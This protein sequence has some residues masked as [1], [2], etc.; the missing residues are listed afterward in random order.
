MVQAIAKL[1]VSA[2]LLAII[3]AETSAGISCHYSSFSDQPEIVTQAIERCG[4]RKRTT[5]KDKKFIA[6]GIVPH[7]FLAASLIIEYFQVLKENI[8][9][10]NIVI[11]GPDHYHQGQR[12]ISLTD[13]QW[14]TPFGYLEVNQHIAKEMRD[15]IGSRNF[16]HEA[17]FN[18][19]SIGNIVPFIKYFFP[20]AKII[21]IILK[22]G[23]SRVLLE[24]LIRALEGFV[25][26][27][28]HIILS[29]DFSHGKS[30]EEAN[31]IDVTAL[32]AI[33]NGQSKGIWSLDVDSRAGLYVLLKLVQ[34]KDVL[35][36]KHTNAGEITGKN[37]TN[38]TSYASIYFYN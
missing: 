6:A 17:F 21:P 11:I 34:G 26:D 37:L 2:I 19:H 13:L 31:K 22:A 27:R 5:C 30:C 10:Q 23:T 1:T 12:D 14:K 3:A 36:M 15:K 4:E 35:V 38:C 8:D 24:K 18:E 32:Q 29:M 7:H 25:D 28:T 9:P 16:D 33:K 20:N